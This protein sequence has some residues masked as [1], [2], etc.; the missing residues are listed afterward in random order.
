MSFCPTKDI[1]SIYL[2]NELPEN[3]KAEYEAHLKV[4]S[5]CSQELNKLRTLHELFDSDAKSITPDEH[6][7]DQSYDRLK[8]RMAFTKNVHKSEKRISANIKYVYSAVAAVAVVAL[9][10]PIRLN[11]NKSA[12]EKQNVSVASV[13]S[14]IPQVSTVSVGGGNGV[15]I[16]GNIRESILPV[17]VFDKSTYRNN[18][19]QNINTKSININSMNTDSVNK[20]MFTDVDFFRPAFNGDD[21]FSIKITVPEMDCAVMPRNVNLPLN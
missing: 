17:S 2:D 12:V 11:S 7:L 4:C 15:V 1:H 20:I 18:F 21:T 14:Q 13:S 8:A 3:Y 5:K 19:A 6:Y 9:I 10:I 16:S